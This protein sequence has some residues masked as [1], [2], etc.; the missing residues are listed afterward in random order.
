MLIA[1][2]LRRVGSMTTPGRIDSASALD[3]VLH[4]PARRD[5]RQDVLLVGDEDVEHVGAGV[6]DHLL[7]GVDDFRLLA[8]LP[9]RD[10][11]ALGDRRRSRDR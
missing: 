6:G 3:D 7:E 11:E 4:R 8:D 9:G 5:H 1:S 2:V 10:A